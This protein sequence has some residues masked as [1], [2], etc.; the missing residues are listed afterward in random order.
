MLINGK[1]YEINRST[2]KVTEYDKMYCETLKKIIEKG[3]LCPNRT[4]IETLS[5]PNAY[6]KLNVGKEFPILET[7]KVAIKNTITELLWIYQAQSN[8]VKWLTDR[9]NHIW[10]KWKIDDD[11]IYRIYDPNIKGNNGNIVEAK[12]I[13]GVSLDKTKI[14]E[15]V[16]A[17]SLYD[18]KTIKQA[19]SYPP[20]LA[21]TIGTAYGYIVNHTKEFDDVLYDLKNNPRSRRMVVS[22]RQADYLKSGVLEPCVW[23]HTYKVYKGTLNSIV[24][25]RSNDMPLGNPFNVTQYAVLL[26]LLAK[27]GGFKPGEIFIPIS[28]CHIY[29]NQLEGIKLQLS[30]YDKLLKWEKFIQIHND[31]DVE[32]SYKELI[33]RKKYLEEKVSNN[34]DLLDSY[35]TI[36]NDI[37]EEIMCFE[38]L[39]TRQNPYLY[40]TPNKDFYELDNKKENEDIKVLNYTS[41]P[42]IKMPVAQ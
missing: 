36:I 9:D 29:V 34:P 8:N 40:I 24:D 12:T 32:T 17:T 19:I 35:K 42:S 11:G 14:G 39:I 4:G 33:D 2:A 23:S 16:Y 25:I 20:E 41:L 21:G 26:S 3:E 37:N 13:D 15:K 7:K 10:D 28:D 18:D 38:H 27:H 31:T 5:I 30:R 6:F 22:L 1:E